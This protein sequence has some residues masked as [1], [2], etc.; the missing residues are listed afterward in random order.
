VLGTTTR[1][2][3]T[4]DYNIPTAVL[5]TRAEEIETSPLPTASERIVKTQGIAGIN[6]S[7]IFI[8]MGIVLLGSCGILLYLKYR[9]TQG[10]I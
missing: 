4:P 10:G 7:V 5:V 8:G 1:P 9:N 6:L 3:P 2:T